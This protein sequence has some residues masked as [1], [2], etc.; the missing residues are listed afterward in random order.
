MNFLGHAYIARNHPELIAGNFAGDSYKGNLD[1]FG[2]IPVEIMNGVRLHRF[3]D[4]Y[5][6]SHE[7]IQQVARK[8]KSEGVQKVSFIASDILLDH[9]LSSK[10]NEYSELKYR[11]FIDQVYANT[12][13]HLET[14]PL[15]F[16]FIYS[17][18]KEYGWFFD[19]QTEDGIEKILFQFSSRIGF[20][21]E[22]QKCKSIYV[23]NKEELDQY[24]KTFINDIVDKSEGFILDLH[25]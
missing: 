8:F 18:L 17:R 15:D 13:P 1:K 2:H 9:H 12:D 23:E 11:E 5:T 21:N 22:L 19:Y 3:I 25:S 20:E 7:S 4:D 14:L 6:D 10:W 16:N 24:F